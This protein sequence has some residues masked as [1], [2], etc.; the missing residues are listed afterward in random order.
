MKRLIIP[1]AVDDGRS[2][3]QFTK[4]LEM[5]TVLGLADARRRGKPLEAMVKA[6]YPLMLRRFEGSSIIIDLLGLH[7]TRLRHNFIPDVKGFVER[8]EKVCE[9]PRVYLEELKRLSDHFK[10]YPK[11]ETLDMGYLI[12]PGRVDELERLVKKT[13]ELGP[14][15]KPELFE[16]VLDR[17]EIKGVVDSFKDLREAVSQDQKALHR[18]KRGLRDTLDIARKVIKEEVQNVKD[19]SK[20]IQAQYKASLKKKRTRLKKKL[21][22]DIARIKKKHRKETRPLR[23]E[24]TKRRRKVTRSRKRIERMEKKG[25]TKK[26]LK[27]ERDALKELEIK[28][29]ELDDAVSNLDKQMRGEVKALRDKYKTDIDL[30]KDKIKEERRA[31][32]EKTKEHEALDKEI[33]S[34]ADGIGRQIDALITKKRNR[35]RTLGKYK[36]NLETKDAEINIP[37]Y[38]YQFQGRRFDYYPP[39]EVVGTPGLLSRFRRMLADNLESKL[40]TLIR[41]QSDT[42]ERFLS[43]V[44]GALRRKTPIREAYR[45]EFEKINLFCNSAA[46]GQMMLGLSKLRE[47]GWLNDSEYIRL[48]DLL[49]KHLSEVPRP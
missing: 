41:P 39:V 10:D 35:Y 16:S 24:R 23:D 26:K 25:E 38:I 18:A 8:L 33:R 47:G 29:L 19:S 13:V 27:D 44:I 12:K 4:E 1:Y 30:E 11:Y 22:R 49:V 5:A 28:F 37:F 7:R 34:K 46:I 43:K 6:R 21:D 17:K 45:D 14:K 20:K 3:Q 32:R 9:A 2:G 42:T 36:V 15:N 40:N 48:Q 31:T